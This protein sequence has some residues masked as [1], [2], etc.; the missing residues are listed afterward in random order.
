MKTFRVID[1]ITF[2]RVWYI[3]APDED[4]AIRR[5]DSGAFDPDH[6]EQIDNTPYEAEE[7]DK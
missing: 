4:E 5:A 1:T 2:E 7:L 6:E 3:D